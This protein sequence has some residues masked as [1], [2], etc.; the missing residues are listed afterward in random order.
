M[1]ILLWRVKM[2]WKIY[3]KYHNDGI[4]RVIKTLKFILGIKSCL[5][6]SWFINKCPNHSKR[7]DFDDLHLL[8]PKPP[9]NT[10]I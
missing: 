2:G 10:N 7:D 5:F 3:G 9:I 6:P 4:E 8:R 1:K